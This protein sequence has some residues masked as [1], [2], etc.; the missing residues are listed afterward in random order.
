MTAHS[1]TAHG[2]RAHAPARGAGRAFP[3]LRPQASRR[4][5]TLVEM[6]AALA[7]MG[8]AMAVLLEARENSLR[9]TVYAR[10]L[11]I[12]QEL[13][14]T[15][16]SDLVVEELEEGSFTEDSPELEGYVTEVTVASR[17]LAGALPE[18]DTA[19]EPTVVKFFEVT[20]NVTFPVMESV[21]STSVTAYYDIPAVEE[22]EASDEAR[23]AVGEEE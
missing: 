6:I 17:E 22:E 11:S 15:K 8:L 3:G 4:G 21:R 10:N 5:I 23:E 20:V 1:A 2:A 7:I 12:A 9:R 18:E 13:I 16:L 14:R 19:E